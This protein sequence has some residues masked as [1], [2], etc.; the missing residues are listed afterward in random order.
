MFKYVLGFFSNA[1]NLFMFD[2]ATV[3]ITFEI[4]MSID[5]FNT[6]SVLIVRISFILSTCK[7]V[8]LDYSNSVK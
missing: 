6:D 4:L 8:S 5:I 2:Q 7:N 3:S 1:H